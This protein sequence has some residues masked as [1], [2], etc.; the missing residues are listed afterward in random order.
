MGGKVLSAV[1]APCPSIGEWKGQDVVVVGLESR[2]SRGVE[3]IG[4]F[5]RGS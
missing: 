3:G 2:S 4:D 5:Q 1:K